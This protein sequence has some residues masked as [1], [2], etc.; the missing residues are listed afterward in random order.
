M[1]RIES[2]K[3]A[4]VKQWK[5]LQTKKGRDE[6]GLFLLEGFHLVEEAVKSR[7]PLVELMV[8]ERTAIPPGWDVSVPVVIVTEAVMKAI[9]ST[10]TP[11]G[12]A[13]VCRQLPAE[14]E[15]VKTALLIDA[16][17]DPGNL[18]TMI[19]TADAAGIDAVILGE[20][21]ADVYNPKVVR[22]TQ[23][24][25]F[26]L[27]VVKGDLAQWIARFKEQG[28]PVYGTALE[29]AVDYRTV[30]PSSSFALLVGNEG[31]GVRREWLEMTTETIY[32]PIYGQAES[33]NVAVAAGILL[34]S[35]QAVR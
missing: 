11:Q 33:L 6:T 21:C 12:I 19:R 7:A 15:G 8:D 16:V 26:H 14:L 3:N 34:Y 27:P 10:E 23:G 29:N 22:A 32:I 25:L 1:K 35:L 9:S 24:S 31:S 4:R 28:I 17:Q 30:P 13:A 20:G 2:P 5:K 18:G